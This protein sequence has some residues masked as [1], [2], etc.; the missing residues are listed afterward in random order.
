[1]KAYTTDKLRNVALVGHQGSGKTS[2]VEAMLYNTGATNRLG[3]VLEKNTVS[4]WEDDE[5]ER[6]MSITTALVP[7]EFEDHKINLLDAPGFTDFQ[8]EMKNA[9]RVADSVVV[10]V[11]AVSGVE[12]GT[13]LVWEYARA[14]QQPIIVVINKMDR[15]NAN[16]ERTLED[17]R[18]HFPK[19]KFVPVMIPI[20][21]QSDFKGVVNLVTEKAYYDIGKDRADLPAEMADE[22]ELYRMELIEA[23]AESD[24]EL[25]QKYFDEES[26]DPQEIRDGMRDASRSHL[27]RTV[28][29]FVTSATENV[30]TYPLMEALIAYCSPPSVR[31]VRI[32]RPDQEEYEYI[33]A[34]QNSDKPLAA[35]V[36]K[37]SN[38]KYGTLN[39]FRIFSGKISANSRNI[40]STSGEEERF[41][42]LMTMR[43]K[44]QMDVDV[45]HAGDIGVAAKLNNTKTGDTFA[46]KDAGF[47]IVTPVFPDPLYMVAVSPRTQ[48]DSAKLGSVLTTLC[49]S[50]PTLVWRQDK[51]TR[52]TVLEGMGDI[53][54]QTILRKAEILGVGI[55]TAM[56]KVPYRETVT[57]EAEAEYTHR[58]QS[59]GAGQYGRVNLRVMPT[60]EGDFVYETDI[61]GG[62]IS[63][64]F[65]PSIEKGIHQVLEEGIIAGYPVVNVKAVVFDGKEHAVDSKDIA[66]QIAGREAFRQAFNAAKPSLLEPIMNVRVT[67]PDAM[68]G[69]IMGDLTS[70]RGRVQGMDNVASKSVINAQVPLAEML[71]YGNDLRSMTGGRGIY[72]MTF[73]HYENVPSHIQEDVIKESLVAENA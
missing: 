22:A 15:E 19:Y 69:D 23:A 21:S 3:S 33:K 30:G 51:D 56:P 31:R 1:M 14:Y 25:M 48:A 57:S 55:D 4:D 67:V 32:E 73:S 2:L 26:L 40:N 68:M 7:L 6:G 64:Q 50:D 44:E 58:K 72:T 53:H 17:L 28:P 63:Q 27:L 16:F 42:S 60:D 70:R 9:I 54:I 66:F 45:L 49:D 35:Y 41:G 61:F 10:V 13:E 47:T 39:Y 24:D 18:A 11:D 8:G 71:R 38:D 52:Q 37:T 12:V 36:W 59:G 20:G 34:P 65:L 46:D 5:R 62:A 29:V 43:G